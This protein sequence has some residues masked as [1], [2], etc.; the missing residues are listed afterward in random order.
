MSVDVDDQGSASE[1]VE[2]YTDVARRDVK[3]SNLGFGIVR[4]LL[5][6]APASIDRAR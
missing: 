3:T 2:R 5:V 6:N 1:C 4:V